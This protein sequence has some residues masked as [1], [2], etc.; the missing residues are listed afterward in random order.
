MKLNIIEDKKDSL[1]LE[2]EGEQHTFPALLCWALLKDSKVKV[3][4][5]DIEQP[6]VGK[7]KIYIRTKGKKPK[8]AILK[9]L[10]LIDKELDSIK[11]GIKAKG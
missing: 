3:A 8:N 5:Y 10:D 2:I 9:S 7:P 4:V 1:I 6:L 11:K